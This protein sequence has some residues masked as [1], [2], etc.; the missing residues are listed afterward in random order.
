MS[1]AFTF[2][3]LNYK[4]IF[5]RG[6]NKIQVALY[7]IDTKNMGWFLLFCFWWGFLYDDFNWVLA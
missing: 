3:Y 1:N 6:E 2:Y 7:I 5:Q 4:K